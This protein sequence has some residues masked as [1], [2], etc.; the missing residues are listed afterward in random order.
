M[1]QAVFPLQEAQMFGLIAALAIASASP[2]PSAGTASP[3]G[4]AQAP[5]DGTYYYSFR[6]GAAELGTATIALVRVGDIVKI[7]ES[8]TLVGQS[9]TVDQ[10]LV[11]ATLVPATLDATY[12]GA[13]PTRIHIVFESQSATET[14]DGSSGSKTLSPLGGAKGAIALDGPVMSGFFIAP[15]QARALGS[16]SLEGFSPGHAATLALTMAPVDPSMRP[17]AAAPTDAGVTVTGLP[18]GSVTIWY[19]PG[20]LLPHDVEVPAQ[21]ISIVLVR[22]TAGATMSATPAPA[23]TPL[24][25]AQPHFTSRD[26]TFKSSDGT[27][28]A[29]TLTIP[30]KPHGNVPAVVLVHGSGPLDRDERIGPNPI[31]LQLSNA[32][33]N[34]GYVVLR[35]DKRG[36]GKSGGNAKTFTRNQLLADARAAIAYVAGRPEVNAKKTFVVGH[37]EGGELAPSLAAGGA[38]L[39]GIV[40]M[41]PP[42]VPLDQILRQ[43]ATRGLTG[44]AAKQAL[45][46]EDHAIFAIRTGLSTEAGAA[47]LRSSFGIDP[48]RVI[49]HV[50]C[51]ILIL[52]GGKDFQVLLKDLPRLLNAAK[53]AHRDVAV[54]V[55][56][57][58]DHLFITVPANRQ[59]TIAEYMVPHHIDPAMIS[60]LL[61]WTDAHSR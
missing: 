18:S 36:T 33:S 2:N 19:D 48:A 27:V 15:A 5:P 42:A 10:S 52:Q 22:Q 13:K 29:G 45:S 40:L 4:H 39:R 61:T 58:D 20:T 51:P 3:A 60:A 25:T 14:V 55:F 35:Y 57:N 30:D 43:Q 16:T 21:A 38:S 46:K 50:P 47:W 28:L 53:S 26:V 6:Q 37:S 12:P 23:P 32:L 7:H 56:P 24:P 9:F 34:H 11:P 1:G 59:A 54:R 49:Q 17:S 8:T 31:F 44:D 41:A